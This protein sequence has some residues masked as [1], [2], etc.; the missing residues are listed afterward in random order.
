MAG[1]RSEQT[2]A[3]WFIP[4]L[5]ACV[6]VLSGLCLF[7]I[8]R[9]TGS[10]QNQL[11]EQERLSLDRAQQEFRQKIE[12]RWQMAL[13]AL[14]AAPASYSRLRTWDQELGPDCLG[15]W[16]DDSGVLVYPNYRFGPQISAL[17]DNLQRVLT[18]IFSAGDSSK[19]H[20]DEPA[21]NESVYRRM[22]A[23]VERK[24]VPGALAGAAAILGG[25]QSGHSPLPVLAASVVML[26]ME[27]I[28]E[29]TLRR[30]AELVDV[31]LK[32]YEEGWLPLTPDVLPWLRRMHEQCRRRNELESWLARERR[33]FRETRRI[34]WA[35]KFLPR[36]NL[37]LRRH[38]YNPARAELPLQVLGSDPSEDPF[39]VLCQFQAA[40]WFRLA[41]LA[42][43]LQSF[44]RN[45]ES[46]IDQAEWRPKE[47][48]VQIQ[49]TEPVAPAANTLTNAGAAH[50]SLTEQRI[51]HPWA[52]Q[53]T[54]EARPRDL[55]AFEQRALQKN[56]LY[57]TLTGLTIGACVLVLF[58]GSRALKEQRRLSKLRTDFVTNVSHELRTPLTAIRLH[59]ETL[60]RQLAKISSPAASSAE[61]IV[62]EVD[63]LS[64]LINDVLEFTRLE[65]D[66]KRFVWESVDLVA[67]LRDSLQLFSQHLADAGFAVTLD[68]PES[69]VLRKADRAALKQCAV[70]LIS[71]CLKF[72]PHEKCLV[73][74][75]SYRSGQAV[76][77]TEDRGIGVSPADRQRIF[78]KFYR[79][80]RLDPAISGTGLGL[81]L[82]K[83]FVEA[84]GGTIEWEAPAT[85]M[86][87]RFVI[88]LPV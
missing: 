37:L 5:L 31:W 68:L 43:D 14:P 34:Q 51:L 50:S 15:F 75:L 48:V 80:V 38:L 7:L 33:L 52:A 84:H 29:R 11:R 88:R 39:L 53:F 56:L 74:R 70:N 55:K 3:F 79:G 66:K 64:V 19:S 58:L 77:E 41:G 46:V 12:Q 42:V 28:T 18:A 10:E 23:A 9:Q 4:A 13:K 82:C 2:L 71:N 85:G 86:G 30:Q 76:W 8:R 32:G 62:E 16:L 40:P 25:K 27:E 47:L 44:S 61:T 65:N 24:D 69:L 22:L 17:P 67:V 20:P 81:T 78:D 36:L 60:E 45:L 26:E 1:A 6:L 83:A 87:S 57:L 63:R 35:E 72:S 49:R 54:I 73:L 59:A 21:N